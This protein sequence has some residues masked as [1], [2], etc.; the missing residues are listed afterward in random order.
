MEGGGWGRG[1]GGWGR[2]RGSHK[3]ILIL[4][5]GCSQTEDVCFQ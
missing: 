5:L 1:W 4:W 2:V 3:D